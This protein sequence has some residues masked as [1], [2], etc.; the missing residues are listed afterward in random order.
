[1]SKFKKWFRTPL[2]TGL[3]FAVAAGLLV[4]S[5]IGIASA[6]PAKT[7]DNYIAEM[8]LK[9]IGVTLVEN[10]DPVATR[11]YDYEK[12]DGSWTGTV[13]GTLLTKM[14]DESD[15]KL[16]LNKD[17]TEKLS[18]KNSGNINEYVRVSIYRYWLGKD[19]KTKQPDLAPELI[20]LSLDG[21]D[22]DDPETTAYGSWTKD[23][24]STTPERLVLYY[25]DLLESG[26]TSSLFA[27][28][29]RIDN[30]IAKHVRTEVA[31]DTIYTIYEYDGVIFCMEVTVDA[32]QEHSA[33]DAMKSAWG[34]VPAGISLE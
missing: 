19:G 13:S 12:N 14:L 16:I 1:M 11:D 30:E 9:Y 2:I 6:V 31:G 22:L 3:A 24:D 32:V 5:G 33:K 18:V 29:I 23:T 25:N 15:G 10:D 27:D 17:Y 20:H 34:K 21:A 4:F 28:T 26:T 7:S 8:N